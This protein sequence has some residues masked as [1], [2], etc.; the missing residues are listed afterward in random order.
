MRTP[1]PASSTPNGSPRRGGPPG[2]AARGAARL[3]PPFRQGMGGAFHPNKTSLSNF[4]P[5]FA[6][7]WSKYRNTKWNENDDTKLTLADL[8]MLAEKLTAIPPSFKLHP[9]VEKI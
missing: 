8:Q 4:K 2:A 6:V 5:P 1:A 3:S 7:D 9:R